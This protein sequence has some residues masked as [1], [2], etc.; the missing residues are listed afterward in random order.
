MKTYLT[1]EQSAHLI[2]LGV[3]QAKATKW[4]VGL[5]GGK[6]K[7]YPLFKLT[8]L[9]QILPATV[10][11][12]DNVCY[13]KIFR[14]RLADVWCAEYASGRLG[15]ETGTLQ[16]GEEIIDALYDLLIHCVERRIIIL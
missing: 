15:V 4:G 11:Y 7:T 2:S 6:G 5:V 10:R 9:L 12:K 13:L 1:K 8:D 16:P 14:D 3:D